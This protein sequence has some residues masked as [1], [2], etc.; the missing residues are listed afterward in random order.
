MH[1]L[2]GIRTQDPSVLTGE[3]GSC[4]IPRGLRERERNCILELGQI[5]EHNTGIIVTVFLPPPSS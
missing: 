4:L 5:L 1:A 2:N 3:D